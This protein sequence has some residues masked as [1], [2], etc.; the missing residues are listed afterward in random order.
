M[1]GSDRWRRDSGTSVRVGVG[2]KVRI[3]LRPFTGGMRPD[4]GWEE[5]MKGQECETAMLSVICWDL[6]GEFCSWKLYQSS[7]I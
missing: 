1:D 7:D 5:G 3:I 2:A 6:Q 4:W